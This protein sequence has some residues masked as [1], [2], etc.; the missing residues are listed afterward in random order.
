MARRE[1]CL[2][3]DYCTASAV[4]ERLRAREAHYSEIDESKNGKEVYARV[5]QKTRSGNAGAK[6]LVERG[7]L[8]G[9]CQ[10]M[11][12]VAIGGFI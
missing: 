9:P 11:F 1:Q 6:G 3:S 2:L 5:P 8:R 7:V 10:S 12:R 4:R